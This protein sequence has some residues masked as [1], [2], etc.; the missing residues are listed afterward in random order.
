MIKYV[1]SSLSSLWQKSELER[2]THFWVG[3]AS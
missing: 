3:D 2:S 1:L